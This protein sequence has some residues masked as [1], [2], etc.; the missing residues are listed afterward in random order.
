MMFNFVD[1][2]TYVCY[3]TVNWEKFAVKIFCQ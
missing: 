3:Y 2:H 1:T